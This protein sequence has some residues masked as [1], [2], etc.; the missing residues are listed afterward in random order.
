MIHLSSLFQG[1]ILVNGLTYGS[2]IY[3]SMHTKK[4]LPCCMEILKGTSPGEPYSFKAYCTAA[5]YE[6]VY[7]L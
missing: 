1:N 2:V 6:S 3:M 7:E 5:P 4:Q